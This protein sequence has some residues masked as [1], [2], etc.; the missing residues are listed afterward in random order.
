MRF[1]KSSPRISRN[2]TNLVRPASG[3]FVV[4]A[5]VRGE[6]H[7]RRAGGRVGKG[8]RASLGAELRAKHVVGRERLDRRRERTAVVGLTKTA[9]SPHTSRRLGMSPRTRAH[10][11]SPASRAESPKGSYWAGSA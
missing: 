11:A 5:L 10:P 8:A 4:N 9:S 2:G 7:G 1:L 6:V 3:N